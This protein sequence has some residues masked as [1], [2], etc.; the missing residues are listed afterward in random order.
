MVTVKFISCALELANPGCDFYGIRACLPA[1]RI[2]TST[3]S[4]GDN[5]RIPCGTKEVNVNP[6]AYRIYIYIYMKCIILNKYRP[7]CP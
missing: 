7:K 2:G 6:I 5:Y 3:T 1:E 4:I